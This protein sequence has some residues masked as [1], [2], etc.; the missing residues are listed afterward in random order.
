MG[1]GHRARR[2]RGSPGPGWAVP[3][4]PILHIC[5]VCPRCFSS[6]HLRTSVAA[7][8]ASLGTCRM[9]GAGRWQKGP[10]KEIC[11]ICSWGDPALMRPQFGCVSAK[12]S[13]G[14]LGTAIG[15]RD[16]GSKPWPPTFV[17]TAGKPLG[18]HVF[19]LCGRGLLPSPAGASRAG[20]GNGRASFP[21]PARPGSAGTLPTGWAGGALPAALAPMPGTPGRH[22]SPLL[23]H[24]P[25][26]PHVYAQL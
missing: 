10:R 12:V 25:P 17:G 13:G 20:V 6:F 1:H 15:E 11:G 21:A 14:L 26:C 24:L 7:R 19:S 3:Y 16:R 8:R 2:C 22:Q 18:M 5:C 9:A 4:L 23:T